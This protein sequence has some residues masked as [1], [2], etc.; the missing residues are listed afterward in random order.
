MFDL[1]GKVVLITGAGS[2]I[3]A[4]MAE[5]FALAGATI[6]VA[7]INASAG[8][9]IVATLN[10][11]K[12]T[13]SFITLNVANEEECNQVSKRV[14]ETHGRLDVLINNAGVGSVG[15]IL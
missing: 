9:Q 14:L 11:T 4:A 5:A 10:P 2:G 12:G 1:T 13:A 7:D 15:T 8:R 6:L 3:G